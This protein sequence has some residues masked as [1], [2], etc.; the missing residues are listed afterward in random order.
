MIGHIKAGP[1]KARLILHV[2]DAGGKIE[3]IAVVVHRN[4]LVVDGGYRVC[5]GEGVVGVIA[6]GGVSL[7]SG[8]ELE[9]SG[10]AVA[11]IALVDLVETGDVE[12]AV[13]PRDQRGRLTGD[14]PL[15]E[16]G[17]LA[18]DLPKL[19]LA[20]LGGVQGGVPGGTGAD[21]DH[22]QGVNAEL[23]RTMRL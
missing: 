21:V 9:K 15:A 5:V 10:N 1:D 2:V 13:L 17:G 18:V 19:E 7:C 11:R 22:H 6:V 23:V 8:N 3:N 4:G 20:Q 12:A 14:D 16:H